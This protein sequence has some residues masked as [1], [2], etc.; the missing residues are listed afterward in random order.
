MMNYLLFRLYGPLVSWGDLAVGTRRPSQRH[1][2]KSAVL[3]L[4]AAALGLEREDPRQR[5]LFLDYK[6]G[7]KLIYS[8]DPLVDYHTIQVRSQESKR[9]FYNRQQELALPRNQLNTILSSRDYYQDQLS[10]IALWSENDTPVFSMQQIITALQRPKFHLYLGR[11]SCPLSIP[12]E[13]Q[14]LEAESL[15]LAFNR[16]KFNPLREFEAY[17]ANGE[18]SYFWEDTSEAGLEASHTVERYDQMISRERWQFGTRKE[19]HCHV[20]SESG[21]DD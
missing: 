13:A 3:G 10:V 5:D 12:L 17:F 16:A 6:L 15:R 8:G 4:V 14:V 9:R 20:K 21:G 19:H 11:K 1:P 7:V 18:A 2:S